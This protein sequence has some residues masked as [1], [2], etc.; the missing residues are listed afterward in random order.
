MPGEVLMFYLWLA[1]LGISLLLGILP[2]RARMQ[3]IIGIVTGLA[4]DLARIHLDPG[5]AILPGIVGYPLMNM[6]ASWLGR[7]IRRWSRDKCCSRCL[8]MAVGVAGAILLSQNASGQT[9]PASRPAE[10]VRAQRVLAHVESA[11]VKEFDCLLSE[12]N[13]GVRVRRECANAHWEGD[14]FP[15]VMPTMA[16]T[17]LACR[18]ATFAPLARQRIS[19]LIDLTILAATAK[20]APPQGRLENLRGFYR[21]ATYL[22]HL[23]LMLGCWRRVGGDDRYDALHTHLSGLLHNAL[24]PRQ[25]KPIESYPELIWPYDTAACLLSLRLYDRHTGIPRSKDLTPA[26]LR[27]LAGDGL[28]ANTNLP[29]SQADPNTFAGIA[30]PRGCDLSPRLSML[31]QL[32]RPAAMRLYEKYVQVFWLDKGTLRG[33]AEW[34]Y[35]TMAR[36]DADS[37][38]ILLGIG[39]TASGMGVGA[40][41]ACDDPQRASQ[42]CSQL[43]VY[44]QMDRLLRKNT[45][46]AAPDGNVVAINDNYLT[47]ML[48]GDACLFYSVTWH[49]W[50]APTSASQ[51]K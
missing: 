39:V 12:P 18:D 19:Q 5:P 37:G 13:Y 17:S 10:T 23:N 48:L 29:F 27:W 20:V 7:I 30:P 32:D 35:G 15:Y 16:Y 31:A 26:H 47:G 51:P 42:L 9:L 6:G 40:A 25:G 43:L 38:P 36:A 50:F 34:P 8:L 44:R 4:V 22:G 41:I 1:T 28:D 3:N 24:Q 49:D 2:L 33:F 45:S 11:L 46:A 14:L 21:H